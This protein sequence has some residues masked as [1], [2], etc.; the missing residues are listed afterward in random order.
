MN[1]VWSARIP[2]F[3]K[4]PTRII[5]E[6]VDQAGMFR[7]L[8]AAIPEAG[9]M[10][11]AP[12][13]LPIGTDLLADAATRV[14]GLEERATV[15][16]GSTGSLVMEC[17][18]GSAPAGL[19][20]SAGNAYVPREV[21]MRLLVRSEGE[22]G[23][24]VAVVDRAT[25]ENVWAS[26]EITDAETVLALP[27]R[28][29]AQKD[30]PD[31]R[32]LCPSSSGRIEIRSARLDVPE[33][34]SVPA[35]AGAWM[36]NAAD[37]L[38]ADGQLEDRLEAGG[39]D[40][41]YLQLPVAGNSV[42]HQTDLRALIERLRKRNIDTIAVEGDPEMVSR[43]GRLHALSRASAISG[44]IGG[45]SARQSLA[46][47]QYDIEPYLGGSHV[48][49]EEMWDEW[50]ATIRALADEIGSPVSVVVPFWMQ[51]S[52]AGIRALDDLDG[53]IAE[54]VVMAYRTDEISLWQICEPWLAY[55]AD[56]N[57]AVR[58]ALENG[59]LEKEWHRTYR[60]AEKGPLV[61]EIDV[62]GTPMVSLGN[63][64]LTMNGEHWW[65]DLSHEVVIDPRRIS[66]MGDAATMSALAA[67]VAPEFAAW[68]S[69]TGFAF[70]G[71]DMKAEAAASSRETTK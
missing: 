66:F 37:A 32:I 65:Y 6:G 7:P 20:V 46:G 23:F 19:L 71:L 59:I 55:G 15:T 47:V 62:D 43:D 5:V 33:G 17:K 44:F 41:V 9:E 12:L 22:G 39:I 58:I 31:I 48:N 63:V 25:G 50:K 54:I 3:E 34:G 4:L 70:H 28:S 11:P 36:W 14:F 16:T 52:D 69:F 35:G 57:R 40:Q 21:P 45:S 26:A 38:E 1:E 67:R 2:K 29:W 53:Q 64:S 61:L 51:A 49:P 68:K 27:S 24:A 8:R 18:A 10:S 56:R 13:P 42:V 60:R 30:L